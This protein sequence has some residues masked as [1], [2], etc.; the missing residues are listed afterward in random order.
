[1]AL[2]ERPMH[3]V[4]VIADP[5]MVDLRIKSARKRVAPLVPLI[6]QTKRVVAV[7]PT[8]TI[9]IAPNFGLGS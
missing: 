9:H 8:C 5:Q 4:W 3:I 6:A 1:M 7:R 2:S